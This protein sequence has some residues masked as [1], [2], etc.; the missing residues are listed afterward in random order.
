MDSKTLGQMGDKIPH[1]RDTGGV[2]PERDPSE[3]ME[4]MHVQNG[5]CENDNNCCFFLSSFPLYNLSVYLV[6]TLSSLSPSN[7]FSIKRINRSRV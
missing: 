2:L 5:W 1:K 3:G 4:V 6:Y 7:K